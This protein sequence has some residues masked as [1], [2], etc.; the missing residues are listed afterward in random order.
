[1]KHSTQPAHRKIKYPKH[2]Q[3]LARERREEVVRN[4]EAEGFSQQAWA[5]E[6]EAAFLLGWSAAIT[7]DNEDRNRAVANA[8][9]TLREELDRLANSIK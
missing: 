4:A 8:W 1:M 5:T 7:R 3:Q 2:I 9:L 6:V